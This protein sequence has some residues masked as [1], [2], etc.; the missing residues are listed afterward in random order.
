LVIIGH[1]DAIG[2]NKYNISLSQKR[3]LS[4]QNYLIKRGI[5][6]K[7]LDI[8]WEGEMHPIANNNNPDGTDNSLGRKFNRRTCF[9]FLNIPENISVKY[10][11]NIP[12]DLKI[13]Y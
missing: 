6:S 12:E 11:N 10:I 5:N 1:T 9:N 7:R 4:V 2:G 3:A 8:K 13:S